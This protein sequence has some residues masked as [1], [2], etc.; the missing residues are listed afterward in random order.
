M[1]EYTYHQ[2][3]NSNIGC[4]RI[5]WRAVRVFLMPSF[6][7]WIAFLLA[8]TIS[9]LAEAADISPISDYV[10]GVLSLWFLSA[11]YLY[12]IIGAPMLVLWYKFIH[13]VT[14]RFTYPSLRII[15]IVSQCFM[16]A[17]WLIA[18][19]LLHL[20][21]LQQSLRQ[22]SN[23]LAIA[24]VLFI[25]WVAYRIHRFMQRHQLPMGKRKNDTIKYGA[26]NDRRLVLVDDDERITDTELAP[27]GRQQAERVRHE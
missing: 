9:R 19:L 22:G 1:K 16:I 5:G 13:T 7:F 25:V 15:N 20:P 3:N 6:I 2:V 24:F 4:F 18:T 8:N 27:A 21:N 11:S 14:K 26:T 17:L 10:L 12:T 23:Q